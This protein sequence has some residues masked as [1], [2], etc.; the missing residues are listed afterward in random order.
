MSEKA[1]R[2]LLGGIAAVA[3]LLLIG[4]WT[5]TIPSCR[6]VVV[7]A[8]QALE[9]TSSA[10]GGGE[11]ELDEAARQLQD[12]KTNYGTARAICGM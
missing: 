9:A 12:I 10:V 1:W 6:Q 8:E 3:L 4:A 5:I 2:L 11:A 7:Y